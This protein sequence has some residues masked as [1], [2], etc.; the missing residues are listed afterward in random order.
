MA[1]TDPFNQRE[2]EFQRRREALENSHQAFEIALHAVQQVRQQ[3]HQTI[4]MFDTI[5]LLWGNHH[6]NW[7]YTVY[8]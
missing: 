6:Y 2:R 5:W 7:Y 1:A 3:T 4:K 8:L